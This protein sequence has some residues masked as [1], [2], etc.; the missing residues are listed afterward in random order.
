MKDHLWEWRD[1]AEVKMTALAEDPGLIP[2]TQ[3]AADDCN[4]STK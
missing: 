3:K 4:R 1:A 2:C